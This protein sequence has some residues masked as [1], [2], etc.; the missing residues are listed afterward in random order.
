MSQVH[1]GG[2]GGGGGGGDVIFSGG[3]EPSLRTPA[4]H[5]SLPPGCP[6]RREGVR[7]E[8]GG[9]GRGTALH[10][11]DSQPLRRLNFPAR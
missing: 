5:A 7:A 2:G 4:G 3:D 9:A 8:R 6:G 10:G 11:C 1:G